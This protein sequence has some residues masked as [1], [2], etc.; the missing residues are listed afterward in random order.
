MGTDEALRAINDAIEP[1]RKE[2]DAFRAGLDRLYNAVRTE[3]MADNFDSALADE[4]L[5]ATEAAD[6]L[7]NPEGGS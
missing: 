7:L 1:V 3:D 6:A 2:R 5:A 4:V